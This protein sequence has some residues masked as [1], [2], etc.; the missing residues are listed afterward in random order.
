MPGGEGIEI[1]VHKMVR[2]VFLCIVVVAVNSFT[3]CKGNYEGG[4]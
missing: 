4:W 1:S 3:V 2:N